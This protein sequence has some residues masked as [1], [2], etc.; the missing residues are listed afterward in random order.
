M[1]KIRNRLKEAFPS[2]Y[3]KP[4][5]FSYQ[6]KRQAYKPKTIMKAFILFALFLY[7]LIPSFSKDH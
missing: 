5:I 6:L 1:N 2:F 4:N 7:L 3:F